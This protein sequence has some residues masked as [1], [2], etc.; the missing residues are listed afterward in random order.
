MVFFRDT[1]SCR[2]RYRICFGKAALLRIA[3]RQ[4]ILR[5]GN[6]FGDGRGFVFG[7]LW[8]GVIFV[9]LGF[10]RC[11]G[12]VRIERPMA[13]GCFGFLDMRVRRRHGVH[14]RSGGHQRRERRETDRVGNRRVVERLSLGFHRFRRKMLMR[15]PF[16]ERFAGK[17]LKARG[18]GSTVRRRSARR[19]RFACREGFARRRLV[20]G[21]LAVLRFGSGV[22]MRQRFIHVR[23]RNNGLMRGRFVRHERWNCRSGSIP[24]ASFLELRERFSRQQNGNMPLGRSRFARVIFGWPGRS[25]LRRGKFTA[26]T[27]IAAASTSAAAT[28]T[29]AATTETATAISSR[30]MPAR[31]ILETAAIPAGSS[32]GWTRRG[33]RK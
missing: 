11:S 21:R 18:R 4:F 2:F 22:I 13:Q 29:P 24:R 7:Q 31:T 17:R 30:P 14:F 25:V 1:Q 5:L 27:A 12:F 19:E 3:G 6:V 20:R 32:A 8:V 16:R 23:Y 26:E 33:S 28:S 15:F 10:K 9:M